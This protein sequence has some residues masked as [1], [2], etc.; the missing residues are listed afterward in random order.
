V[1]AED[2]LPFIR[3][4]RSLPHLDVAGLYSHFATSEERDSSFAASQLGRFR[5]LLAGLRK[6]KISIPLVHFANSGAILKIPES[7]F[8]MVRPG[9]MLYGYPP[10]AGM[11]LRYPL[12]PVLSLTSGVVFT[13]QI[14]KGTSVS[15]GRKYFAPRATKIAT[16]PAGYADGYSRR[17]T[18]RAEVLIRGRKY[19]VAGTI[20]MDHFMVDVGPRGQ[21][22]TGDKVTLLGRSGNETIHGWE[23]ARA[24]G[25]IPYELLT[26]ISGRVPREY[27]A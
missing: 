8:T 9:I 16:V 4:V 3:E 14:A 24:M 25:T 17:L 7:H 2:A 21:V 1:R 12:K 6:E 22:K 26:G 15:Y 10:A 23:L 19:P 5:A 18:G 27:I 13:K 20:C 11:P